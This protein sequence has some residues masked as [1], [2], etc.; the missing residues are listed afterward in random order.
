MPAMKQ[1]YGV[2][3]IGDLG[4]A[5][6]N[7][8]RV[9][10][11]VSEMVNNNAD[12]LTAVCGDVVHNAGVLNTTIDAVNKDYRILRSLRSKVA[13]RTAVTVAAFGV[14]FYMISALCT[15]VLENEKRIKALEMK[16]EEKTE[17]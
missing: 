11:E 1:H 8:G 10:K 13:W 4:R 15:T 7:N 3:A 17:E 5:V 12:I 16:L 2:E 14:A 9:L 6:S